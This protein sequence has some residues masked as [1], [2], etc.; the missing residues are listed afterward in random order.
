MITKQEYVEIMEELKDY[1]DIL[2]IPD[3]YEDFIHESFCDDLKKVF[4]NFFRYRIKYKENPCLRNAAIKNYHDI[5][6][7]QKEININRYLKENNY[8]ISIAVTNEHL[9]IELKDKEHKVFSFLDSSIKLQNK[10]F[11][12]KHEDSS[13]YEENLNFIEL[14]LKN[15][16]KDKNKRIFIIEEDNYS[17]DIDKSKYA[18]I[19]NFINKYIY[20]IEDIEDLEKVNNIQFKTLNELI[21]SNFN[22]VLIKEKIKIS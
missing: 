21:D 3:K 20:I 7:I 17:S 6:N 9:Y 11:L 22:E 10:T 12:L 4:L 2:K 14:D 5:K 13:E 18:N 1:K 8:Y 19:Y 15:S 16:K